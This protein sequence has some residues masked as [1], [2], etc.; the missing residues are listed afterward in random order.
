MKLLLACHRRLAR[1]VEEAPPQRAVLLW[2]LLHAPALALLFL[3]HQQRALN[4]VPWAFHA[5]LWA[6]FA[7]QSLFLAALGYLVGLPFILLGRRQAFWAPLL[8]GM[9]TVLAAADSV[10]FGATGFHL[11]GLVL[12]MAMEREVLVEIGIHPWQV[13]TGVA[14]AALL[15]ALDALVGWRFIDR[16][17]PGGRPWRWAGAIATGELVAN[18]ALGILPMV[19]GEAV[20]GASTVLPLHAPVRMANTLNKWMGRGSWQP[21]AMSPIGGR[22]SGDLPAGEIRFTKKPDV[23]FVLVESLR[24]D[25]LNPEVMPNLWARSRGASFDRH[26]ASASS[27]HFSLFSLF[28]SL[29]AI[30]LE[31]TIGAERTPLLFDALERHGYQQR[32]FCA[33]SV[34]WMQLRGSVFRPV[35]RDLVTGYWGDG[36]VR[37]RKMVEDATAWTVAARKEDPLFL[38]LFFVGTHFQYTFPE[39]AAVFRPYWTGTTFVEAMGADSQALKQRA[40]NAA[41][42]VDRKVEAFLRSFEATRGGAPIVIITSDHGEEFR[43]RGRLGHGNDV[44]AEQV[45]VPMVVLAPETQGE[46]PRA[47]TSHVDV[48]PTIFALLG[49]KNPPS[50]YSDGIP[51]HQ[52]PADRYV[53]TTVGWEPRHALIGEQL[54]VR[55]GDRYAGLS[56]TEVTDPYDR[57]LPDPR[58]A[59]EAEAVRIARALKSR[60]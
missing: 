56:S 18:L 33:S 23:V 2:A 51:M 26:Y 42:E 46:R 28:F 60:P 47:P 38:F 43:E 11:N 37:D 49:D 31:E 45:H 35:E 12:E 30:R 32:Y 19:A 44:N 4:A 29:H 57:P 27:T 17:A 50:R 22:V 13:A 41:W 54:K 3:P 1:A 14:G 58:A 6:I 53:M 25:F 24:A 5:P 59:F 21:V 7:V 15:I 20:Y 9:L 55:F 52:A 8:M 40:K 10:L 34:N 36:H 48:V 16:A 39:D